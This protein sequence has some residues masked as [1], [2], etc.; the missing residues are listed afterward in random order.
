MNER[1]T[2]FCSFSVGLEPTTPAYEAI[3][4]LTGRFRELSAISL[5]IVD[6]N[7]SSM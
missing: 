4:L 5:L 3:P 2:N 1:G 7:I 6:T